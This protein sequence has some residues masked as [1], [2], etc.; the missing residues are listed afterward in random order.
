M[1]FS[2]IL[3]YLFMILSSVNY[4][5][6]RQKIRAKIY[7]FSS[8]IVDS[9]SNNKPIFLDN[10]HFHWLHLIMSKQRHFSR[11]FK[12]RWRRSQGQFLYGILQQEVAQWTHTLQWTKLYCLISRTKS[13]TSYKNLKK[14]YRQILRRCSLIM[15]QESNSVE[16]LSLLARESIY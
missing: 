8:F 16:T 15:S 10:I 6:D 14:I 5:L 13:K 9:I 7:W 3:F 2:R 1:L 11:K 4:N 12:I